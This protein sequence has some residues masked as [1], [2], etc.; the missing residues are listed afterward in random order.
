MELSPEVFCIPNTLPVDSYGTRSGN[1]FL[2]RPMVVC[3]VTHTGKKDF[4][5]KTTSN[6]LKAT[7]HAVFLEFRNAAF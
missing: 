2:N 1:T 4:S 5:V 6:I 7:D 3:R